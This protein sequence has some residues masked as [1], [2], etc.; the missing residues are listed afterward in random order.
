[1]NKTAETTEAYSPSFA[2][3]LTLTLVSVT[4]VC[5]E[6]ETAPLADL[7]SNSFCLQ[8]SRLTL[9]RMGAL[10]NAPMHQARQMRPRLDNAPIGMCASKKQT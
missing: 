7:F 10:V 5:I 6:T 9:T 1:M 3:E 2:P 8:K 4:C